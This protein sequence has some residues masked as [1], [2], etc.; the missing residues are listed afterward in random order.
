[1]FFKVPRED[2]KYEAAFVARKHLAL[3][4]SISTLM[5]LFEATI[6]E[7]KHAFKIFNSTNCEILNINPHLHQ[8]YANKTK[9]EK[10]NYYAQCVEYLA[11]AMKIGD[12]S[13]SKKPYLHP[14]VEA[15]ACLK[16]KII[17]KWE[18]YTVK[19]SLPNKKMVLTG[20][21]T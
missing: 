3:P 15:N 12:Y 6:Q 16:S 5:N 19:I 9:L 18:K 7:K 2:A 8:A 17:G 1:M 14:I 20:N 21:K 13:G 11:S 4:V 10:I